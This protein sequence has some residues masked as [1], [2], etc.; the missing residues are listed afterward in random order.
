M[1]LCNASRGMAGQPV[2]SSVAWA[3]QAGEAPFNVTRRPA[4]D[5]LHHAL[6]QR[7][8]NAWICSAVLPLYLH[9][10]DGFDVEIKC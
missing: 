3:S 6:A 2:T 5:F 8:A 7:A 4:A 10:D 9:T 1:G